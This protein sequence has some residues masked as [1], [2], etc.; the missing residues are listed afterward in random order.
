L[1]VQVIQGPLDRLFLALVRLFDR[2]GVEGVGVR[3]PRQGVVGQAAPMLQVAR[4]DE[5]ALRVRGEPAL[6]VAHQLRDL[7]VADPV[8][9][10]VVQ[11]R[12]EHVE[13]REQV[14]QARRGAQRERIVGA[15]APVRKKRV[16]RMGRDVDGVAQGLEQPAQQPR[17]IA[18]GHGRQRG[19]ERDRRLGQLRAVFAAAAQG[20]AEHVGDG[21][22]EER[23]GDVRAVVD[24]LLQREPA[25]LLPASF[26]HQSDWIDVEEQGGRAALGVRLGVEDVRLPERRLER[27][28]ARG[29]LVQQVAEI[30]RRTMRGGDGE[31]H[32]DPSCR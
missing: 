31:L 5:R 20:R 2:V 22:A 32:G 15:L 17:A 3:E 16:E 6:A 4:G 21:D 25:P 9:L 27:L 19:L 14:A 28:Q 26:A 23:R 11:H 24:V 7:V 12:D 18:T 1:V 13:V 8:V 29:V 30:G 10:V